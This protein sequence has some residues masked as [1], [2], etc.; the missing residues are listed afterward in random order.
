MINNWRAAVLV[1]MLMILG[2]AFV[3]GTNMQASWM[4]NLAVIKLVPQWIIQTNNVLDP[5]CSISGTVSD[6]GNHLQDSYQLNPKDHRI[7]TNLGRISWLAGNCDDA[8]TQWEQSYLLTEDLGA[9]FELFRVANY[10]LMPAETRLVL[11]DMA[12]DQATALINEGEEGIAYQWYQRGFILVPTN[13]SADT[14]I[15]ISNQLNDGMLWQ[16]FIAQ[17]PK[18][19]A[20][21]WWASAKLYEEREDWQAAAFAYTKG[22]ELTA[23]P[24]EFW[25]QIGFTWE[26]ASD[27]EKATLAYKNAIQAQPNIQVPYI[28]LGN[29]YRTQHHYQEA[30]DWYAKAMN[31]AS[32]FSDPYYFSGITY[33]KMREHAQARFYLEKAIEIS[34]NH[35]SARVALAEVW[36]S[37][38]NSEL[39][40]K[41][42][43]EA[44][45]TA[46]D[47]PAGLWIQLGDWRIEWQD[48]PGAQ[49]AYIQA[50]SIDMGD[51]EIQQKL[52][53]L[54]ETCVP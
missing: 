9:E 11:A 28:Q 50:Q 32:G 45:N 16:E 19:E 34:P 4:K 53:T 23:V 20:A 25:M 6:I 1:F 52:T 18:T 27:S 8:I 17:L 42:I 47:A 14:L 22:V 33:N 36:H 21:Y 10:A 41:W 31:E 30:L 38:N 26:K 43:L 24:Y 49:D 39:A 44:I 7:L 35:V 51:L 3:R 29:I 46:E 54:M 40:E 2:T 5:P 12:Y 48:C 13:T 15:D 37:E